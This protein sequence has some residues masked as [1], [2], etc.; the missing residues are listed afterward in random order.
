MSRSTWTVLKVVLR[1]TF[2]CSKSG[3]EVQNHFLTRRTTIHFSFEVQPK[4]YRLIE[5]KYRKTN[6]LPDIKFDLESKVPSKLNPYLQEVIK[7]LVSGVL[8]WI[9]LT[10]RSMNP[11]D[12]WSFSFRSRDYLFAV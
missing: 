10:E 9:P 8:N 12:A 3:R 7:E 4:K 2:Y 5:A 1:A 11:T 6:T